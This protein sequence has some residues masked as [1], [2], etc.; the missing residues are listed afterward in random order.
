MRGM[1]RTG[2]VVGILGQPCGLKGGS[3]VLKEGYYG[4]G[5]ENQCFSWCKKREAGTQ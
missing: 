4:K 5:E 3:K 2:V 1:E